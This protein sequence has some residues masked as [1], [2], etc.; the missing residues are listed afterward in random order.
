MDVTIACIQAYVP[1]IYIDS[2]VCSYAVD[3]TLKTYL[4][5]FPY[6][7]PFILNMLVCIAGALAVIFIL[8][9]TLPKYVHA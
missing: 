9:E 5:T 7:L 3:G 4:T 1:Y 6:S 8:P 2:S